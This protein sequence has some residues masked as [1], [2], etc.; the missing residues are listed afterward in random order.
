MNGAMHGVATIV[1]NTPVPKV[2]VRPDRPASLPPVPAKPAPK[3]A[4]PERLSPIANK[5]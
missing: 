1:A 4:T 2:P 5:R 3:A